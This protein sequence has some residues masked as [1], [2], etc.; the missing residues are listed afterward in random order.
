MFSFIFSMFGFMLGVLG[1]G[2]FWILYG[3][4]SFFAAG[5]TLKHFAPHTYKYVTT[6]QM[7]NSYDK[8]GYI[9][10]VVVHMLF[11][12]FIVFGVVFW[13]IVSNACKL[14]FGKL[15]WPLICKGI[16]VSTSGVPRI[17]LER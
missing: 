11:W 12:P 4:A 7:H 3:A 17:K 8:E 9:T 14:F 2:I 16:K 1:S 5:M 13:F 10:L 15:I 6:G